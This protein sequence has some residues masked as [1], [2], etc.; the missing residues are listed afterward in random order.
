ML[1]RHIRGALTEVRAAKEHRLLLKKLQKKNRLT[2]AKA[3]KLKGLMQQRPR[4]ARVTVAKAA[5]KD[6]R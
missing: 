1:N 4:W 2:R 3:V 5:E 6:R